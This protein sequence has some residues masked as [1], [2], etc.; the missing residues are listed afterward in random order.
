M[1]ASE[2]HP[3]M[4]GLYRFDDACNVYVLRRGDR[5]LAID[6]GEGR[7][8]PRLP[9]MGIRKLDHVLITH[10]HVDQCVGLVAGRPRGCAVHAPAGEEPFL[11]PRHV[12]TFWR[13]R[14]GQG[15]P[16][17][18]SVLDRGLPG[19]RYDMGEARD[20]LDEAASP[21]VGRLPCA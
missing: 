2:P 14:H 6:F 13:N 19:V 3:I 1:G 18:Y 12:R 17:S 8:V 15:C 21:Q 10:H 7:W 9:G 11:Q 20:V 4:D 16:P 5:G